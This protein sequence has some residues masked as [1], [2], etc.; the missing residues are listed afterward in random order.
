MRVLLISFLLLF[1][2]AASCQTKTDFVLEIQ[3]FDLLN[4]PFVMYR[5]ENR[6]LTV[7]TS[8]Y[9]DFKITER[10]LYRRR[11]S[12]AK[13]DSIFA[14]L[15]QVRIDSAKAN[16]TG[17]GLDGL[18]TRGFFEGYGLG[19]HDIHNY[20]CLTPTMAKLIYIVQKEIRTRKYFYR[21]GLH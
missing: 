20:N 2:Q 5:L 16:C 18:L 8:F 12:Q 21:T 3:F 9:R 11:I 4:Q 10:V 14:V 19:Q 13:A 1:A 7:E 6:R 15:A 17:E